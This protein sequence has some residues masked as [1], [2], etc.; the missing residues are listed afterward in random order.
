MED[1]NV[2]KLFYR[3]ALT[4]LLDIKPRLGE[5]VNSNH[6]RFKVLL[7][8]AAAVGKSSLIRTFT[9][10][11]FEQDYKLTI[12]LDFMIQDIEINEE[13]IPVETQEL[14]K[15]SMKG[16]KKLVKKYRKREEISEMIEILKET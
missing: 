7:A 4:A 5:I 16:Y 11:S 10:K 1:Q 15:K 9:K 12:G 6:F 3:F 13:D 14:I 8:G 2:E